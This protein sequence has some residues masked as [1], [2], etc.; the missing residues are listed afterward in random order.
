MEFEP[1]SNDID[2]EQFKLWSRNGRGGRAA[3]GPGIGPGGGFVSAL[4]SGQ[5][6]AIDT[7]DIE[8]LTTTQL[9]ALKAPQI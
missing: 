7:E 2:T 9:A 5:L 1:D 8:N 3:A 4:T 6:A